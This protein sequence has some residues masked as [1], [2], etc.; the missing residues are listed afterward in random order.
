MTREK[1]RDR[2]LRTLTYTSERASLLGFLRLCGKAHRETEGK[3]KRAWVV[4]SSFINSQLAVS[5]RAAVSKA[6]FTGAILREFSFPSRGS[7]GDRTRFLCARSAARQRRGGGGECKVLFV[8]IVSQFPMP[9]ARAIKICEY[10][11]TMRRLAANAAAADR[12][13]T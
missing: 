9:V 10:G 12:E 8:S 2:P 4:L 6:F 13:R 11:K 7:I 1:R 3:R 5:S